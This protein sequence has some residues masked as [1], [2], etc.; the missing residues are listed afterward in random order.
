MLHPYSRILRI[1]GALILNLGALAGA[2]PIG[3][4]SLATLLLVRTTTGSLSEAGSAAA[5]LTAGNAVGLVVQGRLIDRGG[6]PRVLLLAG[7]FCATAQVLLVVMTLLGALLPAIGA[8]AFAGGAALP[9]T[10]SCLRVLWPSLLPDPDLL[11]SAYALLAVIFTGAMLA[12][13]LLVSLLLLAAGP[14]AAVVAAGGLAVGGAVL[15]ASTSASRRWKASSEERSWR[16]RSL[17]TPGMRTLALCN[18]GLGV[19]AGFVNVGVPAAAFDLKQA[20]LSGVFFAVAAAGEVAGGL[21]YGARAWSV[22][23]HQRLVVLVGAQSLALLA[24]AF[25]HGAIV[26]APLMLGLGLVRGPIGITSSILLDY[27]AAPG[28]LTEAYTILISMSLAGSAAGYAIGGVLGRDLGT[29]AVFVAAAS[30]AILV[31]LWILIRRRTLGLRGPATPSR[32]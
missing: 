5:A 19:I 11:V 16:P 1:P 6:Q 24:I 7:A 18:L 15:F 14:A 8:L 31:L 17:E 20:A 12:G 22:P 27:V 13:P 32:Q 29:G 3:M 23:P 26:L 4:T 10:T 25:G 2:L 21:L 9:A 28:S 30:A